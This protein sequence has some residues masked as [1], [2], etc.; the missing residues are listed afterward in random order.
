MKIKLL[1]WVLLLLTSSL[2]GQ[3]PLP[4]A[5]DSLKAIVRQ[6]QGIDRAMALFELDRRYAGLNRDSVKLIADEALRIC[7]KLNN[8]TTFIVVT[9]KLAEYLSRMGEK[10]LAQRYLIAARNLTS[11]QSMIP[12]F[13]NLIHV[14][15]YFSHYW[16]YTRYDSAVYYGLLTV[17]V[18]TDSIGKADRFIMVGA[19]YNKMGDN[20]KALEY[21]NLAQTWLKDAKN[22]TQEYCYLNNQLGMLY[23]DE[24]D[25]EKAEEFYLKSV[26]LGRIGGAFPWVSP[27]NNLAVVYDLKGDYENALKYL[28]SAEAVFPLA[29]EPRRDAAH[30]RNKG[31]VL[32]HAGRPKEGI[33]KTRQAM[34]MYAR[35]KDDYTVARMHFQLAEP[36]R[37]LGDYKTAEREALR[38]LEWDR[39]FG[40]GEL[41]KESY[42]ELSLIY[43]ATRR[44]EKAFDYQKRY[45]EILDSLNSTVRRNKFSQLEK[46]FEFAAQERMREDLE[47]KSELYLA[48]AKAERTVRIYLIFGTI[49]LMGA[50]IIAVIAYRRTRSQN[51]VL[52]QQNRKIEDQ[53]QQLQEAAK[54]KARFFTNVSH[55]LRTPVTLLNGMLE[56]MRENPTQN[57]TDKKLDIALGS[58]RRLQGM[59]NEVLDLSRIEAGRGGAL[60]RKRRE[61]FP[62]LNR[63][64]LAFESLIA[65]KEIELEYDADATIGL[66]VDID[67]DKFEKII[68]NLVNNAIKFNRNGGW[69]RITASRTDTSVVIQVADSG[70]GIPEKE[71]PFVFDRFY[72]SAS[73]EKLNSQGIGIGLSLVREFTELHGGKVTATSNIN[74]GSCFMVELPVVFAD[75]T[76]VEPVE[77]LPELSDETFNSFQRRPQLLIVEDNDEMRFYLKEILGDHVTM[78]EARHGREALKWLNSNVPD[79]II[80]DV[81]MPEM[82]GYEFLSHLKSS[83]AYRGIPVVMLTARASEE[84]LMHGLG[85]GVDD[86]M[87]KPF[88]AKELKVRIHNLLLNQEI[89]KEWRKKPAEAD[90]VIL[91]TGASEDQLLMEKIRTFVEAHASNT[92]LGIA[93]L[94]D[95]LAMSERQLYRK[96]ATITGMTPA[97]LIKEIRM[98]I[99]YRLLQE[100]RVVKVATL[101]KK[102]GFENA[103]YFSRQFQERFGK[104]PTEFL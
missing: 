62:L 17:D 102:V 75:V 37:M 51:V 94:C 8:D 15:L 98:K 14:W 54:T 69:I 34:E 18:A 78:A 39:R 40:Y 30:I 96:A 66:V 68:S 63:I 81:M 87:I 93:D 61:L 32:T 16:Y 53:A 13:R 25:L 3:S 101:A 27:L 11:P 2:H 97:L 65:Q 84:D 48:E 80:S 22:S 73:T 49:V 23:F 71:L 58:S 5:I 46:N 76:I 44:Y 12:K 45:L 42:K 77:D 4:S 50:V 26:A 38:A 33:E 89:R 6:S 67:E 43:A 99:A 82:D 28:D 64:V 60:S 95:H 7:R 85:L 29:N 57:G 47:R 55:E 103:S 9:T 83:T 59:L 52:Y 10:D 70:I 91:P 56:L 79:L 36:Y 72:Q 1:F 74:E 41:V 31:K 88:N 100:R 20:I 35:L 21:Y 90:E 19:A 24:G 86:Y 104:R 92:T